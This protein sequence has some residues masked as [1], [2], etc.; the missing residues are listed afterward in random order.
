MQKAISIRNRKCNESLSIQNKT[1]SLI[2]RSWIV[3]LSAT[4]L[5]IWKFSV[6]TN[7]NS[8]TNPK[9]HPN[10]TLDIPKT[11]QSQNQYPFPFRTL[12]ISSFWKSVL[13]NHRDYFPRQV[14]KQR[15]KIQLCKIRQ[16]LW[17]KSSMKPCSRT[18]RTPWRWKKAEIKQAIYLH[19]TDLLSIVRWKTSN[20]KWIIHSL[21]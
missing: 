19:L 4:I 1:K 16:C 10:L 2:H 17:M 6:S 15:N 9:T 11:L 21:R 5:N 13:S 8:Q 14:L 7:N 20:L 12:T 18:K 3:S